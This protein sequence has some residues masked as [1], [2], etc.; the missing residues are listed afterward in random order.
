MAEIP[1]HAAVS[2]VDFL[3]LTGFI[4][5]HGGRNVRVVVLDNHEILGSY[6]H[7]ISCYIKS[8]ENPLVGKHLMNRHK[9][10]LGEGNFGKPL[11]RGGAILDI[12]C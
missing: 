2:N 6:G 3:H 12:G 11:A 7:I 4:L 10:L 9:L 1:V 5:K 8:Y